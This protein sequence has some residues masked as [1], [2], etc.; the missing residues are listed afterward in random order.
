MRQARASTDAP[1]HVVSGRWRTT[2]S[3]A[4]QSAV[5]H[6]AVHATGVEAGMDAM[7]WDGREWNAME[8]NGREAK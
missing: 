1:S 5:R 3:G 4:E 6:R 2:G 8:W 7:G